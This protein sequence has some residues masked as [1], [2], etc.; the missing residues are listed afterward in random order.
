LHQLIIKIIIRHFCIF[1]TVGVLI[2]GIITMLPMVTDVTIQGGNRSIDR[3]QTHQFR[4]EVV[5]RNNP[6]QAVTWSVSGGGN[7]T[8][9]NSGTGVLSINAGEAP[10][11]RTVT[12]ASTA[13]TRRS[14]SVV[15]T[16]NQ[17]TVT[18]VTIQGANR[19][20]N[21]GQTHQFRAD[22]AGTGNPDQNVTWS[23]TGG[24]SGTSISST[25][26]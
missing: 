12:A 7:E 5:G 4:A 22:V 18:N 9:I 21:R 1:F 15:V 19:S 11:N 2:G 6:D 24:G 13:N 26:V 3:G 17:P 14:G 10:G 23:V 25:G 8:S 16:V 20:V